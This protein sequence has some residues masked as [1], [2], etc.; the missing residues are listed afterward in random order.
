MESC[1][2]SPVTPDHLRLGLGILTGV[3][4]GL[5][6]IRRRLLTTLRCLRHHSVLI[7]LEQIL[8]L[9]SLSELLKPSVT[10][11]LLRDDTET[12]RVV[13]GSSL[14]ACFSMDRHLEKERLR[15]T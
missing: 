15:Y 3:C 2:V 9:K 10:N 4:N 8:D 14:V 11:G 1:W 12:G 5:G 6:T 7:Q 13:V